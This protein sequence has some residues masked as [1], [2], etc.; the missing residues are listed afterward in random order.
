MNLSFAPSLPRVIL[1]VLVGF[2][3]LFATCSRVAGADGDS[4]PGASLYDLHKVHTLHLRFAAAQWEAMEPKGGSGPFGG[5]GGRGGG[6]GGPPGGGFGPGM[7]LAPAVVTAADTDKDSVVT[8]EEFQAL[9]EKWFQAWDKARTGSLQ[10]KEIRSGLNASL[11][12][13]GPG[14]PGGP[15]GGG[16]MLQGAEGKRNGLSSAAGIEFEYVHADLELDGRSITNIGIRYKGNGTFMES[17]MSIKRS[18]KLHLNEYTKGRKVDG[19]ST[20]NLHNNVTDASWMNELLSHRLYLDAGI[21]ASRGSYARVYV[22]VPG[23]YERQYLGLYSMVENPDTTFLVAHGLSRQGALFKP[24]TRQLFEDL[25]ED[26]RKYNQSYDPKG[27]P[28]EAQKRRVIE[29]SKLVSHADDATFGA[30]VGEFLDV[31]EFAR[32]MAVTTW[33][34]TMDSIL[35]MGQ[36]FYVYLDPKSRKFQFLPWDL[37]HSFGQFPMMGSQTQREQLSIQHPWQGDI[38]FLARVFGVPAFKTRYLERMREYSESL[39]KPERFAAQVDQ[40]ASVL[41]PAV[42]EESSEKADRFQLAVSGQ[43]LPPRPFGGGFRG[44]PPPGG[45]GGPGGMDGPPRGGG[46]GFG[47]PTQPIKAFARARSESVRDQLAG[48]STGETMGGFGPGGRGPGGGPPP[49][50]FGPGMFL[51]NPMF[52]ALDADKSGGVSR[53]EFLDGFDK[54][55]RQWNSDHSGKLTTQQLAEGMNR[56]LAPR[57][58]GPGGPG[59]PGF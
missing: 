57:G 28:T 4:V 55:F 8:R 10:E 51:A 49:G 29:F 39:F 13:G 36:N 41:L 3:G 37:D 43:P 14:G 26:W 16:P 20:L 52:T 7:F 48:K 33:L 22:T 24:V 42:K 5:P 9:A 11:A 23:K 38:K 21:P 31:D 58:F 35:A 17:R 32:F 44:G 54:W 25:G 2:G 46:P 47:G 45:R 30:R 34:S 18:M 15:R 19:I 53:K 12:G 40:L 50:D 27:Q 1:A 59:G 6:P 56:D